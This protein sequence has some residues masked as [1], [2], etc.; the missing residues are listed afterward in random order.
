MACD[1]AVIRKDNGVWHRMDTF[2]F[3]KASFFFARLAANE[4]DDQPQK[5]E[6][7]LMSM[8]FSKSNDALGTANRGNPTTRHPDNNTSPRWLC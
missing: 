6:G 1:T 4:S 8:R 5:N 2:P 7:G 3:V